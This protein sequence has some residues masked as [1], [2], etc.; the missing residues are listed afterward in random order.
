MA[1]KFIRYIFLLTFL[2][3]VDMIPFDFE[4]HVETDR[5][6]DTETDR[7]T[8]IEIETGKR[9]LIYFREKKK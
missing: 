5:H 7:Q 8:E 2:T 9:K 4:V 6:R 3:S 1:I